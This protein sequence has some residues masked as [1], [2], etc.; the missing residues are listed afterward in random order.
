MDEAPPPTWFAP[1]R[2]ALRNLFGIVPTLDLHGLGVRE[3]LAETERFLR[4]A[5]ARGVTV[6]RI[7]YGKGHGSPGGRGVLREVVP[8]WLEHDG[9]A[10]VAHYRRLPDASGADGAVEVWLRGAHAPQRSG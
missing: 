1:L 7:V 4:A 6:V 10:L 8:R 9:G 2:Q 5:R 3:A